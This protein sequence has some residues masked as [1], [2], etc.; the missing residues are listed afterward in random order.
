MDPASAVIGIVSFGITVIGK[1]NEVRKV[2]QGAPKKLEAL[3]ES[4]TIIELLLTRLQA[5]MQRTRLQAE[6]EGEHLA[7]VCDQA[8]HCLEEVDRIIDIVT[9]Y[10]TSNGNSGVAGTRKVR[11]SK[12][13]ARKGDLEDFS[14]KLRE[15]QGILSSLVGLVQL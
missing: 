13:V 5:T 8:R 11:I 1:V 15:L 14:N 3:R 7:R 4:C 10:T 6:A 12:W 9:V 2:I